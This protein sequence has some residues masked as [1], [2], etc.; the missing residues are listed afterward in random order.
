MPPQAPE[1]SAHGTGEVYVRPQG[2]GWRYGAAAPG[3]ILRKGFVSGRREAVEQGEKMCGV[4]VSFEQ[5]LPWHRTVNH[6][7]PTPLSDASAS[8]RNA[9]LVARTS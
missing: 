9:K 6:N 2:R 8:A 4:A 1:P 7:L 3:M 5:M